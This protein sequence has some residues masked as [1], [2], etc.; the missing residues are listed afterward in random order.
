MWWEVVVESA[1]KAVVDSVTHRGAFEN[2][3]RWL[4]W[5]AEAVVAA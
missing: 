2:D 1:E 4:P 5:H 3:R